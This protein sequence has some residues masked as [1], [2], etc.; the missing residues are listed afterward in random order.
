[1]FTARYALS[2]YIKQ[3][4][5]IFKGLMGSV[6]SV[7]LN[8]CAQRTPPWQRF[9]GLLLGNRFTNTILTDFRA[10]LSRK[11]FQLVLLCHEL[12]SHFVRGSVVGIGTRLRDGRSGVRILVGTRDM[13]LLQNV[14]TGCGAHPT[15]CSV[16]HGILPRW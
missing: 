2:P 4:R 5:S 12:I 3:I 16:G 6:H 9:K 15:S 10:N 13:S 14:Q 8:C 11:S 1:V 7:L